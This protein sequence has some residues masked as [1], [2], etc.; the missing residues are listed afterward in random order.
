VSAVIAAG[1][2]RGSPALGLVTHDKFFVVTG[3]H[4]S[5]SCDKCHSPSAPS[6]ALAEGGVDCLACH[7]DS[8][9]SPGHSGVPHYTWAT[10]SCIGCHKDGSGGALPANHNVAFFP[11]TGTKHAAVGCS[12]CHGATKAIADITCVPC[13][14]QS[15]MGTKHAA[16]PPATGGN[17]DKIQYINYQWAS[18]YCLKCHADGQVNFIASH[19]SGAIG[20]NGGGS[21]KPF[22]LTCHTTSAPPG[23]KAWATNFADSSCLACHATKGG[24]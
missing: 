13:H 24:P 8:A 14:A 9:T 6:F 18:A 4:K 2:A 12:E 5:F 1:C 22:C 20:I 23:G 10:G 15:D 17:R 19:P 7:T 16:I 11:V 3:S 21:H